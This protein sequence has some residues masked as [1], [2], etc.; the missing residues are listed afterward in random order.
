MADSRWALN[1]RTPDLTRVMAV[2]GGWPG[3]TTMAS[4][5][6]PNSSVAIL[7]VFTNSDQT[8][9]AI[10]Q[11]PPVTLDAANIERADAAVRT[12]VPFVIECPPWSPWVYVALGVGSTLVVGG[13]AYGIYRW[14]EAS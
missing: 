9:N 11:F 10:R 3:V 1:V 12:G 5:R 14:S 13:V 6:D 7:N 8:A 4:D 2:I